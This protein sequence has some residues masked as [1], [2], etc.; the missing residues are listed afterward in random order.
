MGIDSRERTGGELSKIFTAAVLAAF[1]VVGGLGYRI[2][3]GDQRHYFLQPFRELFPDFIINCDRIKVSCVDGE[4]CLLLQF[5]FFLE[6]VFMLLEDLK[7][8][9]IGGEV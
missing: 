1:Y 8:Y 2:Y 6:S 9:A 4:K 7:L 3:V 5:K